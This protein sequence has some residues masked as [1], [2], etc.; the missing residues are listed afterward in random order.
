MYL[1]KKQLNN[2]CFFLFFFSFYLG[3][4]INVGRCH[5]GDLEDAHSQRYGTQHKQ[6]VVDQDPGQ[7]CMSDTPITGNTE[8][9]LMSLN[10]G[11]KFR[12]KPVL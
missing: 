12:I 7:D 8:V 6:T 2:S 11:I 4:E 1:K 5:L 3:L 10:T 9:M